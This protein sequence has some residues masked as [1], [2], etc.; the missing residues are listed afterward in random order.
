MSQ[1][2]DDLVSVDSITSAVYAINNLNCLLSIVE[3]AEKIY[4]LLPCSVRENLGDCC[5]E[6]AN[7]SARASMALAQLSPS[8]RRHII[9]MLEEVKHHLE[10]WGADGESSRVESEQL[11]L[12]SEML[13]FSQN[14]GSRSKRALLSSL[15][16]SNEGE[17]GYLLLE[18]GGRESE[19]AFR[20]K[21]SEQTREEFA[22]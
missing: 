10:F 14:L 13:T 8:S 16:A 9:S 3:Q 2:E 6:D 12:V 5:G 11:D 18:L 21:I 1:I 15:K 17:R 20:N 22:I 4:S 19:V 7:S